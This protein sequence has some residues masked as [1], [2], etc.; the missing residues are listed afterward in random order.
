[1]KATWLA[2]FILALVAT[3]ALATDGHTNSDKIRSTDSEAA[4]THNSQTSAEGVMDPAQSQQ[5]DGYTVGGE[6]QRHGNDFGPSE[7]ANAE[8]DTNLDGGNKNDSNNGNDGN[9]GTG[10]SGGTGAESK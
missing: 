7:T 10:V 1:M 9:S 4:Q 8:G 5:P 2:P 6:N 3:P